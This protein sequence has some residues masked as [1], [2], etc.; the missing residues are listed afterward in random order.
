MR[1]SNRARWAGFAL[2][3]WAL[4]A[5]SCAGSLAGPDDGEGGGD[6]DGGDGGG[7]DVGGGAAGGA[8]ERGGDGQGGRAGGGGTANAAGGAVAGGVGGLAAG[9]RGGAGGSANAAGAGG[10]PGFVEPPGPEL[11]GQE[12]FVAVGGASSISVSADTGKTWRGGRGAEIGS[13]GEDAGALFQVAYGNGLFVAVGGGVGIGRAMVT[14][15]GVAWKETRF[16][17]NRVSGVA[18]GNGMFMATGADGLYTSTDGVAWQRVAGQT[19]ERGRLEL[20]AY[21]EGTFV[22]VGRCGSWA[23]TRDGGRTFDN[24]A[25]QDG[26][27]ETRGDLGGVAFGNH[28]FVA[29]GAQ[30][31]V[32]SDLGKTWQRQPALGPAVTFG[33]GQFV[34]IRMLPNEVY[35]SVD[36]VAWS[37]RPSNQ[38]HSASL[39]FGNNVFLASHGDWLRSTDG[40]T[41]SKAANP[42]NFSPLFCAYGKLLQ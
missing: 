21:G 38:Y 20:M 9:G 40:F 3:A 41:W 34:V 42:P 28:R 30:T 32:S 35:F 18:F 6:G 1:R 22:A 25:C 24:G 12:V 7:G 17:Q 2:S 5:A 27:P 11:H 23:A 15:D 14:R 13:A 39:C 4:A 33:N 19:H 31:L 10:A 26:M 8:D 29:V 16:L 36:G 37:K